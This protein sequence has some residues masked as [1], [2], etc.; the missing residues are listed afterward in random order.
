MIAFA[1]KISN[2]S[3]KITLLLVCF[4]TLSLLLVSEFNN[5]VER[6]V[7]CLLELQIVLDFMPRGRI[8][9]IRKLNIYLLVF[10]HSY[11]VLD[12]FVTIEV[13]NFK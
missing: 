4:L 1:Y 13:Q 6:N 2:A 12:S 9:L 3:I 10:W 8:E 11:C 5:A 7:E